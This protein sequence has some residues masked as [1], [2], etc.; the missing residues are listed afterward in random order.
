[1]LL[2]PKIR[3]RDNTVGGTLSS[4]RLCIEHCLKHLNSVGP[5]S[6]ASC[7]SRLGIE[8]RCTKAGDNFR[9]NRNTG[10]IASGLAGDRLRWVTHPYICWIKSHYQTDRRRFTCR[11]NRRGVACRSHVTKRSGSGR[12]LHRCIVAC[13]LSSARFHS[14]CRRI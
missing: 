13:D 5:A 14:D 7:E 3:I 12:R 11:R 4:F 10:C 6:G 9:C 2:P 1:M 8:D